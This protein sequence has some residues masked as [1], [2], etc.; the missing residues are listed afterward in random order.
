MRSPFTP[1]L[2]TIGI[3]FICSQALDYDYVSQGSDWKDISE[4]SCGGQLQSPIDIPFPVK[5]FDEDFEEQESINIFRVKYDT[6]YKSRTYENEPT[7]SGF[8]IDIEDGI[9]ISIPN[10]NGDAHRFKALQY[11]FH[12]TSEHTLDGQR[13]PAEIHVVTQKSFGDNTGDFELAVFGILL[14]DN[15]D[16]AKMG[17]EE[18]FSSLSESSEGV[19]A[20]LH[21]IANFISQYPRFYAYQ[22][23]LTTPPC[24]E[25]VNWYVLTQ[26]AYINFFNLNAIMH[27]FTRSNESYYHAETGNAREIQDI[28]NRTI[29][30]LK[31]DSVVLKDK[32]FTL[33][34]LWVLL[35]TAG[36]FIAGLLFACVICVAYRGKKIKE[37][38]A[39]GL[40]V[41]SK[42]SQAARDVSAVRE[43]EI[44]D[45]E[46]ETP[47]STM[48]LKHEKFDDQA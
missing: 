44:V 5:L 9:T 14:T 34:W 19:K 15:K 39:V 3:C 10:I 13:F 8:H 16:I 4:T 1:L 18:V 11:H 47:G 26:P 40:V 7:T 48:K 20:P 46:L 43:I 28:N 27:R 12:Y 38:E 41:A 35:A 37:Q 23:S 32:N 2:L 30:I 29:K 36:A 17:L 6:R 21:E 31:A 22:G 45:K 25:S 42:D 24:T 33:L